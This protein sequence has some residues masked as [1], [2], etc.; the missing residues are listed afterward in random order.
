MLIRR[1][2]G[3]AVL[4]FLVAPLVHAQHSV[5]L[6]WTP[7]TPPPTDPVTSY[8]IYRGTTSGAETFLAAVSASSLT[9]PCAT[10]CFTDGSVA[11]GTLYF[12]YVT[13]V[14][15]DGE[16]SPS[17]EVTAAIPPPLVS[18]STTSLIFPFTIVV[19]SSSSTLSVT[20][21]NTGALAV[22]I[23]LP[24]TTSGTDPSDF[25]FVS[26]QCAT[27]YGGT[28]Q[29]G[30][31]CTLTLEFMPTA[32]GARS[33]S[34]VLSDNAVPSPQTITLSGNAIAISP[35]QPPAAPLSIAV[36][37]VQK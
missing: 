4:L 29:P 32:A 7:G 20:V 30:Q 14:N 19:G 13:A 23:T 25:D 17:S 11:N 9:F 31:A 1:A 35:A 24:I 33:A 22:M 2:L 6:S 18:L 15:I 37:E 21:T 5:G 10:A 26:N 16:S 27:T 34:I 36:L 12:Y 3:A 8:N 28:L